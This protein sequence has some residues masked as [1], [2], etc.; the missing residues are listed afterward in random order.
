MSA[1]PCSQQL[2]EKVTCP[3]SR[4]FG[5]VV[6][7][8][9]SLSENATSPQAKIRHLAEFPSSRL[10]SPAR[11]TTTRAFPITYSERLP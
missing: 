10:L 8:Q 6:Y 3:E 4:L 7:A 9:W 11:L 5:H 2:N 1:L